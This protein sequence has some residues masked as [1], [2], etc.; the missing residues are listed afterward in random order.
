MS[1]RSSALQFGLRLRAVKNSMKWRLA[2]SP[3]ARIM[4]SNASSLA[5]PS[6]GGG[7]ISSVSTIGS[8]AIIA[9]KPTAEIPFSRNV[10]V[11]LSPLW[12]VLLNDQKN[13]ARTDAVD[14]DAILEQLGRGLDGSTHSCVCYAGSISC[15]SLPG[16]PL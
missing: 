16:R 3:Q 14:T 2:R 7:L 8:F 6:T 9:R 15:F 5:R 4:A 12:Q 10:A 1:R 11:T 13:A